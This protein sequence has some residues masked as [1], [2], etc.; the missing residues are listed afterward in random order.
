MEAAQRDQVFH[1][2]DHRLSR[3]CAHRTRLARSL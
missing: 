1:N 2:F 3:G